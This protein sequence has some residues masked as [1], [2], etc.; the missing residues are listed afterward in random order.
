MAKP[1]FDTETLRGVV[2]FPFLLPDES[3]DRAKPGDVIEA[4]TAFV[5]RKVADGHMSLD[6]PPDVKQVEKKQAK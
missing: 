2:S 3:G 4:D 5:M 1:T 6:L